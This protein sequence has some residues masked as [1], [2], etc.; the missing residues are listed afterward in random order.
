MKDNIRYNLSLYMAIC[1]F[2][3]FHTQIRPPPPQVKAENQA[4]AK[5]WTATF[6]G[7]SAYLLD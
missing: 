6:Y 2:N 1:L 5:Y 4:M 7:R 3:L